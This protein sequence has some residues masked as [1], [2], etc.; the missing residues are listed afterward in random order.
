MK[1]DILPNSSFSYDVRH[2]LFINVKLTI[3]TG[4]LEKRVFGIYVSPL[5]SAGVTGTTMAFI[6]ILRTWTL[7]IMPSKFS[8]LLTDL[9]SPNVNNFKDSDKNIIDNNNHKVWIL[10]Y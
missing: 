7:V 9:L 3:F 4:L 10:R 8:Y 5:L 2:N 1:S 6:R